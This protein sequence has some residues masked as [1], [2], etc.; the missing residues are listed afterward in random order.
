M[1]Q[2]PRRKGR[3]MWYAA[4]HRFANRRSENRPLRGRLYQGEKK[5]ES[6][7]PGRCVGRVAFDGGSRDCGGTR[8]DAGGEGQSA[9]VSGKDEEKCSRRDE[10]VVGIAV[11]IQAGRGAVVGCAGD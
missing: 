10:K 6:Q 7:V 4:N 11:E 9:A 3:W 2:P 5:N 8:G 1:A